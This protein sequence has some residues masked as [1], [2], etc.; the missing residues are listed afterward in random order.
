MCDLK[1]ADEEEKRISRSLWKW[2]YERLY[3][4]L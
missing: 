4:L 2:F 1:W 3:G